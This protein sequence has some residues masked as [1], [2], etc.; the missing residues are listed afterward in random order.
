VLISESIELISDHRICCARRGYREKGKIAPRATPN[1]LTDR[2]F[3]GDRITTRLSIF[4][5][6]LLAFLWYEKVRSS[7]MP[8]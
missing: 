4:T 5:V 8:I 3:E 7:A 1:E 6:I 2:I